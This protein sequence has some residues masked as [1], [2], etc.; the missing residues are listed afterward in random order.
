[1]A[2][3]LDSI[4]YATVENDR[5]ARHSLYATESEEKKALFK[6]LIEDTPMSREE[7]DARKNF[8]EDCYQFSNNM[9]AQGL[10]EI[11]SYSYFT[12]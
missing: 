7:K 10:G 5:L 8:I 9:P 12:W 3:Y 2:D 4:R 1:M 6:D 11:Q